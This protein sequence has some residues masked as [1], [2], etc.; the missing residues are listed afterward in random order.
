MRDISNVYSDDSTK[1]KNQEAALI[2]LRCDGEDCKAESE[3]IDPT[4]ILQAATE[5]GLQGS[6]QVQSYV[7]GQLRYIT[8]AQGWATRTIHVEGKQISSDYC[9][10]CAPKYEITRQRTTR[11]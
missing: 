4:S 8:R 5:R 6:E 11:A 7:T 9:P 10:R 3:R 1:P 2:S